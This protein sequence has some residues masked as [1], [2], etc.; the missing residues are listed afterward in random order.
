MDAEHLAVPY[1]SFDVVVAQ[2]VV[3]AIP[4]P[5]RGLALSSPAS[6]GRAARSPDHAH[7]RRN[8][9]AW[10][11]GKMADAADQPAWLAHR[12]PMV[13]YEQWAE[14]SKKVRLLERRALPPL[15]HFWLLRYVRQED[16]EP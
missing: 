8:R 9:G 2:D 11:P 3:T 10:G 16:P 4:N 5:E 12:I 15:G 13:A 7:W 14:R 6:C 1:A